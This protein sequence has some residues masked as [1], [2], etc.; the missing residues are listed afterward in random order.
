MA[1]DQL[2]PAGSYT[3][4]VEPEFRRIVVHQRDGS[5]AAYLSLGAE[6]QKPVAE[7]SSLVFHKY[8]K[9]CFLRQVRLAGQSTV[10]ELPGTQVERRM[11]REHRVEIVAWDA[12]FSR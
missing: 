12:T 4:A 10:R 3:V 2:L 9:S 6:I 1:G 5:G 7:R 8:G 11:T